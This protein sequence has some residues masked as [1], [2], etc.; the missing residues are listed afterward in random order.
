MSRRRFLIIGCG[1]I[2]KRHLGN[3][4]TLGAGEI[5]LI[6]FDPRADRRDEVNAKF[7][8]EVETVGDL[9]DAWRHRPDVAFITAPTS[10][11][12]PIALI[13]AKHRCHLFIEKPLSHDMT[14]VDKLIEIVKREGLV[15][16]VGCNMRFHPGVAAV[17]RWVEAGAIG[18]IVSA[19][20]E[21]GQY[22]PDWHPWEDYRQGYSARRDLGGGAILDCIHEI[23][24]MRWLFGDARSVACLAG[25]RS[26]LEI[27]VEDTAAILVDFASGLIGEIHLDYIQRAANRGCVVIGDEGTIRWSIADGANLYS[28]TTQSWTTEAHPEGWQANQMYLDELAHFLD[29]L[30]GKA[31]SL[32]DVEQ[33]AKTLALA[34]AAKRSASERV[35]V[36]L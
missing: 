15:T 20:A 6:A 14:D 28:P 16:L 5:D 1:S 8:S 35:F 26:R 12:L 29:C 25:K 3:L 17:K 10:M 27:D 22:L 33:G 30:D 21:V 32:Q 31:Q 7:G 2:G 34:L 4:Q 19:R 23:D 18:R 13:A 9:K 36:A 11:H 24:Y